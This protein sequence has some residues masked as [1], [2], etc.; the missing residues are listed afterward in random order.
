MT[1]TAVVLPHEL[2]QPLERR[3]IGRNVEER[4]GRGSSVNRVSSIRRTR[5]F[6][7]LSRSNS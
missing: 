7:G 4:G 6:F 3:G 5:V 2:E 1:T